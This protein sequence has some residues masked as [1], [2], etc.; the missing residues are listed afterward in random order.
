[1]KRF[2]LTR[3]HVLIAGRIYWEMDED[4]PYGPIPVPDCKRPLGN[5]GGVWVDIAEILEWEQVESDE[6][7]TFWPNGTIEKANRI[8]GQMHNAISVMLGAGSFEPGIYEA[9]SYGNNWQ[10]VE[11]NHPGIPDSSEDK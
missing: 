7:D 11:A 6:G 10:R 2:E 4:A 5:S 8:W 9:S 3:E 1:M